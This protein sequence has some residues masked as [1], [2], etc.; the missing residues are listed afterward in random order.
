MDQGDIYLINLDPTIH[1][2]AGKIRPGIIL[3][4]SAMNQYSPKIIVA[5]I[6]SNVNPSFRHDYQD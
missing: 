4:I 3:S 6:T 5:P 2:E 1:S